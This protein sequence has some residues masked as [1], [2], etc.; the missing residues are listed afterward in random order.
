MSQG[1]GPGAYNYNSSQTGYTSG[2]GYTSRSG[3]TTGTTS[4]VSLATAAQLFIPSLMR[5]LPSCMVTVA[6]SCAQHR[7]PVVQPAA[8]S[9]HRRCGSACQLLQQALDAASCLCITWTLATRCVV[10]QEEETSGYD[11]TSTAATPQG[12]QAPRGQSDYSEATGTSFD[13]SDVTEEE[14]EEDDE[15]E[16]EEEEEEE[17]G[18]DTGEV[19]SV[20]D[21]S[22]A[23]ESTQDSTAFRRK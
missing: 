10:H 9:H 20:T 11:E 1:N 18:D 4:D 16:E 3:Y 12:R 5:P 15:D 17:E 22:Y 23:S 14:E 19:S 7:Q 2:T 21:S 13:A 6:S 8:T